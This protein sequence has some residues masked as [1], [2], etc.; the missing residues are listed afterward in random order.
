MALMGV[1]RGTGVLSRSC[2]R[3]DQGQPG[4]NPRR[5]GDRRLDGPLFG[6]LPS[7][8]LWRMG[9]GLRATGR[10]RGRPAAVA[11]LISRASRCRVMARGSV[12][13]SRDAVSGR[14]IREFT[15]TC[16]CISDARRPHSCYLQARSARRRGLRWRRPTAASTP[17]CQ[18]LAPNA[19]DATGETPL[20]ARGSLPR[21]RRRSASCSPA[22][23]TFTSR[24]AR[25]GIPSTMPL[26]TGRL[27][28][29][30][31]WQN[32]G[33]NVNARGDYLGWTPLHVAVQEKRNAAVVKLLL[34]RGA[35]PRAQGH[36]RRN[37]P[38]PG[39][40]RGLCRHGCAA[41]A[42]NP[43]RAGSGRQ[44]VSQVQARAAL[45]RCLHD[46]ASLRGR[47]TAMHDDSS[48]ETRARR[49]SGVVNCSPGDSTTSTGSSS[50]VIQ[51]EPL[52]QVMRHIRGIAHA[53]DRMARQPHLERRR[54][55]GTEV[56]GVGHDGPFR[57]LDENEY[58]GQLCKLHTM[59]R[60][61]LHAYREC[62]SHPKTRRPAPVGI[63]AQLRGRRAHPELHPGRRGTLAHAV[64]RQPAGA[65]ARGQ[66]GRAAVRSAGTGHWR[67]PR[68]APCCSGAVVDS[69]ER[70]RDATARVRA[71]PAA[72]EVAITCTPGFASLWLIPR[73]AR[74]T[75][76]QSA[77]RRARVGHA[78]CAGPGAQPARP[79]GALRADCARQ[80][81][82][83]CSRNR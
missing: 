8:D 20:V 5:A 82:R 26:P 6:A 13:P 67:S 47:A 1:I 64:G 44:E 45:R 11:L 51:T 19:R 63:A 27:R 25:A 56:G 18:V 21:I 72:R 55:R 53:V 2:A 33:A 68:R 54:H 48:A 4:I 62:E 40:G 50:S 14:T 80:T 77:G 78:R 69:L 32:S 57:I 43:R 39:Q 74:F 65:A 49:C 3:R 59:N 75:A 46:G 37:A 73:L 36:A 23:A 58:S 60:N 17:A 83:R 29:W 79:G 12:R 71:T 35:D 66:P 30:S 52:R 24:P 28:W 34:S 9:A 10:W 7:C 15:A 31:C 16:I 41:Q 76:V 61:S 81:G 22:A 70:L 42:L 38:R